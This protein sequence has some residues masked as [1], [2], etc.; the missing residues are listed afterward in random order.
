[1]QK[2]LNKVRVTLGSFL[3]ET[4][5]LP[6]G[7]PWEQEL[8][9]FKVDRPTEVRL[10]FDHTIVQGDWDGLFLDDVRVLRVR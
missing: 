1:M 3:D 10:I 9:E 6:H 5:Q 4:I 7:A 2:N 8:Y